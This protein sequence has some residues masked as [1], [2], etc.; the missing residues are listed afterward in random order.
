MAETAGPSLD[1][2]VE[3]LK[4]DASYCDGSRRLPRPVAEDEVLVVLADIYEA[5]KAADASIFQVAEQMKKTIACSAAC[6]GKCCEPLI[7]ISAQEALAIARDLSRPEMAE[8]LSLFTDRFKAWEAAS[9][10]RP[11]EA[12]DA[13]SR[14]DA[15]RYLQLV[16]DHALAHLM[17]PLNSNASC[18]VHG[19]RP[20]PCRKLWVVET[21][22]YCGGSVDPN[23]PKVLVLSNQAF[24]DLFEMVKRVC[25]GLQHGMGKGIKRE[26]LAIAVARLLT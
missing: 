22:E 12:A 1:E 17:C 10:G 25:A 18:D 5:T 21:W 8:R 9:G 3:L 16:Q 14:G 11:Q 15:Q 4:R 2:I 23:R 19:A 26:P 24:E 13:L 20:L 7:L 6:P